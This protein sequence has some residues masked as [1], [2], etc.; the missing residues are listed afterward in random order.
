[1]KMIMIRM[2]EILYKNYKSIVYTFKQAHCCDK[3]LLPLMIV[4]MLIDSLV[5]FVGIVFP[6]YIIDEL[7]IG[8]S[9]ERA[10]FYVLIFVISG[11]VISSINIAIDTIVSCKKERLIQQHYRVFSDKTMSMDLQDIEN[12]DISNH[13]TRAQKVITWNS[14]NIDGVKNAIGGMI[15]YIL[16]IL[17]CV[18]ILSKVNIFIVAIIISIVTINVILNNLINKMYRKND[19]E[20]TPINRKWNYLSNIVDDYSFGKL[21]RIY[22]L[23]DLFIDKCKINRKQYNEKQIKIYKSTFLISLI[24][25]ILSLLQEC[26]IYIFLTVSA[27]TGIITIGEFSMYLAATISLTAAFNNL[28]GFLI[29]L[30]YTSDYIK[31][32]ID[33]VELPDSMIKEGTNIVD[34]NELIFEFRNVSFKYPQTDRFVLSNI[35]IKFN[36]KEH[37]SLVGDNGVGKSTFIK[38]L[39][40]LYDPTEGEILLNGKNIKEYQ[41]FEY[42]KIFSTVFQ[43]YQLFCFTIFENVALEEAKYIEN[44]VNARKVMDAVGI[45]TKIDSL[46]YKMHTYLGKSFEEKGTELSGGEMQKL[47]ISRAIYKDSKVFIMDEPASN[48]SPIAEYDILKHFS[49]STQHKTVLYISHRLASSVFSDRILVFNKGQIIEDGSHQ[50]LINI[51]GLYKKMYLMQSAYYKEENNDEHG[52]SNLEENK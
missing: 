35:N 29:G 23:K 36:F 21:I 46:P 5:P 3:F 32:F 18:F 45:L 6:K 14:K 15:S 38:L 8:R 25:S 37:I 44:E 30:N 17:G 28:I 34:S 39:M 33:F 49:D 12:P 47:A 51:D 19:V 42:L 31:D 9:I 13:K 24:L 50:Q 7:I 10:L 40:R 1:M 20:L 48:L 22:D 52:K 2:K 11:L 41:Y 43:D 27:V 4:N 26:A 16:Q